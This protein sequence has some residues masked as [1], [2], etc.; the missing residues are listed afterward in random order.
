MG[1]FRQAFANFP[2]AANQLVTAMGNTEAAVVA[3]ATWAVRHF[4]SDP[5][6]ELN[7]ELLDLADGTIAPLLSHEDS[8]IQRHASKLNTLIHQRREHLKATMQ[9]RE[10]TQV[11]ASPRSSTAVA[12][13]TS[14]R[15][16]PRKERSPLS[17]ISALALLTTQDDDRPMQPM[18][19][20]GE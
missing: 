2:L 6:C 19:E 11:A 8:Q 12:A 15:E 7:E 13:L 17:A 20:E 9:R 1:E 16:S 18:E 14:I 10:S 5:N 4:F 3:R